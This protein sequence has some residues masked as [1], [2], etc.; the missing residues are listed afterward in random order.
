MYQIYDGETWQ[1]FNSNCWPQPTTAYAGSDQ[2]FTNG[3]TTA[4]LSANT[5]E[6]GH[7]T[8]A[9]TIVSGTGG[10][11]A[12]VAD[13]ASN[14]TGTECT[15]YVLQ[16]TISTSCNNSS[17]N[18][19]IVFNQTPTTANAGFD[20]II[21]DTIT[22][23]VTLAAN[24]PEAEH[25]T[26]LWTV[27]SGTGGSF[28]DDT[29]PVTTFTGTEYTDYVLQWTISTNCNS[30]SDMVN[31]ESGQKIILNKDEW[32]IIR[33]PNDEDWSAWAGVDTHM[34]DNDLSS[35]CH[36]W[37]GGMWPPA[38]TIDFGSVKKLSHMKLW[39]RSASIPSFYYTHGN[40]K[41]WKIFG[42]ADAP[43]PAT[44]V[45][46]VDDETWENLGWT[47]LNN[48]TPGNLDPAF[49]VMV[50]PSE[51][52]GSAEDDLMAAEAGH[53]FI[54]DVQNPEVRYIRVIITETWDG[55]NYVDF[56]ELSFY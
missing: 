34:F 21:S 51:M 5:L 13:P 28:A 27:L 52:G 56:S 25:G 7:G 47:L 32:L 39:Q 4:T 26:G 42:R 14:F 44:D 35:F 22:T 38:F 53:D 50:K 3:T 2:T 16:W 36:T 45:Q 41:S 29:N 54:F 10:S 18:V 15:S 49:F 1:S 33:L 43:D 48:D 17:D 12:D 30:S 24:R 19:N 55:A 20:Q 8:G 31:I 37:G 46:Y 11:F 6:S 9:W 40:P 23:T